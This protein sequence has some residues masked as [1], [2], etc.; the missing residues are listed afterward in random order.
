MNVKHSKASKGIALA[1]VGAASVLGTLV[2]A[3]TASASPLS[4]APLWDCTWGNT[5]FGGSQGY[6]SCTG[7]NGTN[8]SENGN[9]G[10][11]LTQ[12]TSLQTATATQLRFQSYL[13]TSNK[14]VVFNLQYKS[15]QIWFT[16][17]NNVTCNGTS[18]ICT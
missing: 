13:I 1:V 4:G 14:N 5:S 15:G 12:S 17:K 7:P 16:V 9:K 2:P 18:G 10:T 6:I 8:A 3:S 11:K